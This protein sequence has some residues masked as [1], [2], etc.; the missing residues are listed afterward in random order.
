MP[1]ILV[2]H[3]HLRH[4]SIKR[5]EPSVEL[6]VH[7]FVRRGSTRGVGLQ[8]V[9]EIRAIRAGFHRELTNGDKRLRSNE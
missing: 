1:T 8:F 4:D 6:L 3:L 9:E 7:N 5:G 2:K